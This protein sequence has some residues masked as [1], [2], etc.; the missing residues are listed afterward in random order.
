MNQNITQ[1]IKEAGE[2]ILPYFGTN[3]FSLKEDKSPLTIADKI[4]HDFLILNLPKIKNVPVL[5]EEQQVNFDTRKNWDEYWLIDPLDGTKEFTHGYDDFCINIAL[6]K[7][8]VP[9]LG[10]IYSPILNEL[11]YAESGCGF[12]YEGPTKNRENTQEMIVATSRFHHSSITDNFMLLNKL[13]NKY[14]IGA[15]LKFGRMALGQID[16]YPRFEG[17][18]EWD[19]AAG[20]IILMESNCNIIDLTTNKT[21]TYNKKSIKNNFFLAYR[22][23]IDINNFNYPDYL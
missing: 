12:E 16:V 13:T 17:S 20:Q 11:Y 14:V 19:T 8:N 3:Q 5:S 7:N 2:R 23:N 21:P 6:I 4:S 22:S 10:L 1:I 18:K 9:I 15:A